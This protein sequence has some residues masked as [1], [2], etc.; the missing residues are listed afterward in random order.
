M[1]MRV[2]ELAKKHGLSSKIFI[3][4]L[5]DSGVKVKNHMST[6]DPETIMSVESNLALKQKT[7]VKITPEREKSDEVSLQVLEGSTVGS[8]ASLLK[9]QPMDLGKSLRELNVTAKVDQSL[10]Y[11][12]LLDLG[13]RL[14]F[15]V[16]LI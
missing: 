6:L 11:D 14:G 1:N 3:K 15:E 7:E 13:R 9:I 12:T 4:K 8:L 10:D 2:Y 16:M 5:I